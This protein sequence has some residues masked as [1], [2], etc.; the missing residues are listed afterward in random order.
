MASFWVNM[1][2]VA[3]LTVA[4]AVFEWFL[5]VYRDHKRREEIHG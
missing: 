1:G 4:W 5:K 3:L 2:A